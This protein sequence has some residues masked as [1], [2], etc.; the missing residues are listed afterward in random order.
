[1][2]QTVVTAVGMVSA[3]GLDAPSSCAAMRAGLAAN[4]EYPDYCPIQDGPAFGEIPPLVGAL[5]GFATRPRDVLGRLFS[6]CMQE[7]VKRGKLDRNAQA[8]IPLL[9]CA[10][11]HAGV[12]FVDRM[13]FVT[14]A[15][16]SGQPPSSGRASGLAAVGHARRLLGQGFP[17]V[18][19]VGVHS[20]FELS[21]LREL[22]EA[23]RLKSTRNRDGFIPGECAAAVLLE[24][25]AAAEQRGVAPLATVGEPA[26]AMEEKLITSEEA[27]SALGLAEAIRGVCS[28]GNSGSGSGEGNGPVR[29]VLC[30]MNGESYRGHEWGNTRVRLHELL[31]EVGALWH[32]A[33]CLGDVGSA[34]GPALMA[35]GATALKKG[36]A[37]D[38]RGLVWAGSDDGAR[39]ALWMTSA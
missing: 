5:A 34:T 24:R 9:T 12:D 8:Q 7:V 35:L 2:S 20:Y 23:G 17:A 37:P 36:Y 29:W 1:M 25:R 38:T 11:E 33:D 4:A 18:I 27:S 26:L 28:E 14:G 13:G 22:D 39:A 30:D 6:S 15:E 10:P 19:V 3:V 16:L 21:L 31:S 32:P